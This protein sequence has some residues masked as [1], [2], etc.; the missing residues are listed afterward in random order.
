MESETHSDH[1]FLGQPWVLFSGRLEKVR[2]IW[3]EDR[4]VNKGRGSRTG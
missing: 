3:C 2:K 4:K 1:G